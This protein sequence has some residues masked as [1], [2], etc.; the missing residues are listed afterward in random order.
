[1]P[2]L[3]DEQIIQARSVDL[4]DYLQ[5]YE[6]LNVR[7]IGSEHCLVEHD[8]LKI[9]NGKWNWFSRDIGG[10][11]ALDF[12]VKVRGMDF[13]S[14]VQSL[15]DGMTAPIHISTKIP[16][17]INSPPKQHKPFNLPPANTN[18][19]RVYSYLRSRGISKAIINRCIEMGILY[20]SAKNH[21]C[22][23]VGKDGDT[24][25]FACERGTTDDWKKDVTGS[26]KKFSFCL[27]PENPN[28]QTLIVTES[29][30]D[31]LAHHDIHKIGQTNMDGFRLSLGG[32]GSTALFA[33]LERNAK[34]KDIF[35]ALD[36]DKAGKEAANRIIKELLSNKKL[37]HMKITIAPPP[38]G[39]KDYAETLKAIRQLNIEKSKP[40]HTRNVAFSI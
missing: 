1:M 19:D 39:Y 24:P 16:P 25:K 12:L 13:V 6:P 14:A 36:N 4:L 10:H 18:N 38:N 35:L 9:S 31:A 27:P 34:I 40:C 33:F 11:S 5:A 3:S 7:K 21:R 20:E 26:S 28:S 23:F 30:I 2:S 15:T 8:S 32:I 37:S 17:R 22:V 29:P